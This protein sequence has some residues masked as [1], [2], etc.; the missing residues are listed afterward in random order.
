MKILNYS[1]I[2]G[3]L[4][5]LILTVSSCQNQENVFP[6]FTYSTTY[7]P[8]QYPVRTLVLGESLYYD[9]SNDIN[10][11]FEPMACIGGMYANTKNRKVGFEVDP[12]LVDGLYFFNGT[13]TVKLQMLPSNYYNAITATSFI[14][15]SGSFNGGITVQLTDAFFADSLSYS[16]KYVLPLRI[17]NAQTDS[18]L[19]GKPQQAALPSII[20][21][22]AAKWGV[23]P[24]VSNDWMIVPQNFTIFVIN[25]VNKYNGTYLKRGVEVNQSVIPYVSKGYGWENL[26]IEKTTYLPLLSTRALN[27][28]LYADVTAVSKV[29]FRAILS[30]NGSAVTVQSES[31][32]SAVQVTGTGSF[33]TDQ[34]QWGGK[35]RIAFYLNYQV[36]NSAT[37]KSYNIKDTLVIRDNNVA[38]NTFIPIVKL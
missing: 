18:I 14:I 20:P 12:T 4:A 34:E 28:L 9:N 16:E 22:V 33:T 1:I 35:K 10:H 29:G 30:V 25:Y 15:P 19:K 36:T 23:D 26:F 17:L 27:K 38:V 13:D 2:V 32:T 7:F 8:W 6:D 24:R 31:P 3:S 37:S 21:S 5:L 11:R